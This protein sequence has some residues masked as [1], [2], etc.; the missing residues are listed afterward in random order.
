MRWN[1]F[2]EK[3]YRTSDRLARI[4]SKVIFTIL[5][6][7]DVKRLMDKNCHSSFSFLKNNRLLLAYVFPEGRITDHSKAERFSLKGLVQSSKKS[8]RKQRIRAL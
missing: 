5:L 8:Q 3:H 7:V 4:P 2:P 1:L 6:Q